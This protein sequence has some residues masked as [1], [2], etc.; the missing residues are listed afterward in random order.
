VGGAGS[1]Q[2][3]LSGND[4]E[5]VLVSGPNT[6]VTGNRIGLGADLEPL[7][8]ETGVVVWM[9]SGPTT[10]DGNVIA[11]NLQD[12][13][14]LAETSSH[15]VVHGNW[16]GTTPGHTIH[17]GWNGI[18]IAGSDNTIGGVA[19]GEPNRIRSAGNAGSGGP[20]D[21]VRISGTA[22]RRN[23]VRGNVILY[24]PGLSLAL[25]DGANGGQPAPQL[26]TAV[27]GRGSIWVAGTASGPAGT[28]VTV[29][30]YSS[31]SHCAP[32]NADEYLGAISAPIHAGGRGAF[33][34][35]VPT[36]ASLNAI[37]ATVTTTE[38]NTSR[39]D[40]IEAPLSSETIGGPFAPAQVREGA[41]TA[42]IV[43]NRFRTFTPADPPPLG[44]AS[45][46]YSIR[47]MT[48]GAEDFE[49]V[50]GRVV[51]APGETQKSI[52]VRIVDD[53]EREKIETLGVALSD[54]RGTARTTF[55]SGTISIQANDRPPEALITA[56]RRN[57]R[58]RALRA[59][60]GTVSDQDDDA[61]RVDIALLRVLRGRR[62]VARCQRLTRSG[63][64]AP[65]PPRAGA[66]RPLKFI[67]AATA[68]GRWVH[69]LRKRLPAGRYLLYARGLDA[70]HHA[71]SHLTARDRN[72]VE[73]RLR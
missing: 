9:S 63:Q 73:F 6:R 55:S 37:S 48:A 59:F 20:F 65:L 15:T 71:D 58:A 31:S 12:G 45:A 2:N 27:R 23:R 3:L 56:P 7:P 19:S 17:N 42:T 35:L 61:L 46:A 26:T 21:G 53:R 72:R 4:L 16:I 51:F 36:E 43:L 24:Y 5:G 25:L 68:R 39:F 8:N 34:A 47:P 28:V 44:P 66:C 54:P 50:S 14:E 18:S 30:V 40:C 38:G 10:I 29:D 62:G 11:G 22:A 64:L 69:R 49:A 13:I 32:S 41:G 52:S 70:E 57:G 1:A 67:R 60:S 33:S